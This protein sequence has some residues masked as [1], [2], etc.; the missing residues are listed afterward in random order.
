MKMGELEQHVQDREK[1][2]Y[3][4]GNLYITDIVWEY[5]R[6][7][8]PL[9]IRAGLLKREI[10]KYVNIMEVQMNQFGI[11]ARK[12][13]GGGNMDGFADTFD[14]MSEE[15]WGRHLQVM[16]YSV[17]RVVDRVE[18][19]SDKSA[20]VAHLS[21]VYMLTGMHLE[22]TYEMMQLVANRSGRT[23]APCYSGAM[24][25]VHNAAMHCLE[26]LI[27]MDICKVNNSEMCDA[28][29]IFKGALEDVAEKVNVKWT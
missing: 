25:A 10:K 26:I 21:V 23:L 11:Q 1:S 2:V 16:Y 20:T 14:E 15:K 4:V 8:R 27:P 13:Y 28:Y 12:M 7:T 29:R 6:K 19:D 3:V 24:V 9:A 5:V 18:K 17:K 22:R